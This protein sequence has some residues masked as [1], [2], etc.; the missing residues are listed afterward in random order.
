MSAS[1]EPFYLRYY[2]GHMGRFGHEFLEFDFRVVGD[3]RSAVARYANNSNYR[4]DSLIRKEMC[5]SSVVVD[6]I[7]RII[8]ASEITK[9]DDS[10][11][12]QKNKDGR[13]ELEIRIGNDHIAFETAK[14]GS[15]VDVTESA[16]PEGLRVFYYL[17]QDLKALVFSLIALHFKIK[18][19]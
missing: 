8:K 9:E 16:D 6:E 17:V 19:I 12:P 10:K 3:G 15:L 13:Q 1:N 2:S 14:I 11:W 5:V 4:N 18:P 7:K